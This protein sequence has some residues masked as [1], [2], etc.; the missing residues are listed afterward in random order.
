MPMNPKEEKILVYHN[1]RCTKSRNT[2]QLFDQQGIDYRVREYLKEPLTAEEIIDLLHK[3]NLTAHE[4]IRTGEDIYKL[5]FKGKNLTNEEW[6]HVL[7]NNPILIE[8]P[9]VV[10]GNKAVIARP[11]E[12][13]SSLINF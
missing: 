1:P 7:L 8:R 4:I 10:K 6:I 5:N 11:I 12:N 3:L 13:I 9:I 2:C